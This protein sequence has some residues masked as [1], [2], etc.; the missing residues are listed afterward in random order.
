MKNSKPSVWNIPNALSVLRIALIPLFVWIYVRGDSAEEYYKAAG[1]IA[2][3]GLTDLLDGRIARKYGQI[4]EL[5]KILDP[6]ADK[7]TQAAIVLCLATRYRPF[8]FLFLLLAVKEITMAVISLILLARRQKLDGAMWFGKVATAVFYLCTVVLI[9]LP[10]LPT[11]AVNAMMAV[12]AG[13]LLVAFVL[14][15][16]QFYRLF[17]QARKAA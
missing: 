6:V 13:C 8:F 15:L 3:S 1:V 12:T 4:T 2:L 14:Y 9:A 17:L 7:L 5:G 10:Q 16:R 11:W